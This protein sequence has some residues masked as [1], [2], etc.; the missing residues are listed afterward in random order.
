[1]TGW[2]LFTGLGCLIIG[3]VVG[4]LLGIYGSAKAIE[5]MANNGEIIYKDK[6]QK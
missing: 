4:F 1:M 5:K 6:E 3:I 2:I